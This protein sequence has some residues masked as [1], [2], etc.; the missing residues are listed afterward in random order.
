[1]GV[2]AD[3]RTGYVSA[4]T[5]SFS[6]VAAVDLRTGRCTA[7]HAVRRARDRS[8]RR[9]LGRSVAGLGADVLAAEPRPL[10]R[11]RLGLDDRRRAAGSAS[12]LDA[13]GAP[14]P[15]SLARTG[16]QR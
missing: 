2:S 4:W 5:P 12:S 3:G 11:V 10:H 9:R 6:G 1:M 7:D 8:G 13:V 15:K 14:W 16:C